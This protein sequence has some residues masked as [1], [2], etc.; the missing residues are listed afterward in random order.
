MIV[1]E[2]CKSFVHRAYRSSSRIVDC[3]VRLGVV[4]RHVREQSWHRRTLLIVLTISCVLVPLSSCVE[5]NPA[6]DWSIPGDLPADGLIP[7]T[8]KA[9]ELPPVGP[10]WQYEKD[11][12]FSE[13]WFTNDI[14]FWKETLASFKGK[15]NVRYLEVGLFEG[16]SLFWVL[17]YVLT[18]PS[19]R[20]YG[21]EPWY[22][23]DGLL[24]KNVHL[25]DDF[26]RITVLKGFSQIELPKLEVDSF[27][28]IYIDGDH[29][30]SAVLSD[31][32]QCW[33]LLRK[34]GVMIFDDYRWAMGEHSDL[35]HPL[36]ERPQ[37]SIGAFLIAYEDHIDVVHKFFQVAVRKTEYL[38]WEDAYSP[39]E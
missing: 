12:Q 8:V 31:A 17:E 25:S 24:Y 9:S 30:A 6:P 38:Y 34:G 13:D 2:C 15:P 5:S 32:V 23:E 19:C 35:I 36:K 11:Y 39:P 27:D 10:P 3:P 18:D 7:D 28:I 37:S 22:P 33:P 14:R 4:D 29:K 16:R 1:K 26:D 20:A 21:I